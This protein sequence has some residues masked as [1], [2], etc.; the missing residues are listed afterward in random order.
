MLSINRYLNLTDRF[1]R[2]T[3]LCEAT[4]RLLLNRL[5]AFPSAAQ[6]LLPQADPVVT[7][8]DGQHVAAQAPADAPGDG[9][10]GK[11]RGLPFA[12]TVSAM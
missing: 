1:L 8:A 2:A 10:K 9:I 12:C 4:R 11:G 3:S 7:G 5:D 6:P